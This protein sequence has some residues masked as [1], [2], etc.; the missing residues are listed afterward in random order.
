MSKDASSFGA[1][2][3]AGVVDG[4]GRTYAVRV[5]GVVRRRWVERGAMKSCERCGGSGNCPRCGGSGK[6]KGIFNSDCT[7]CKASGNCAR[8][9]GKGRV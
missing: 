8:C 1:R 5:G 7:A 9:K 2:P 6:I 4:C 3:S